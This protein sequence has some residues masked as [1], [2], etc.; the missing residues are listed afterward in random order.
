MDRNRPTRSAFRVGR[1]SRGNWVAQDQEG[2]RG[3]L[4]VSRT[5]AVRFATLANIHDPQDVIMVPG[6]L[7]LDMQDRTPA[8]RAVKD[9]TIDSSIVSL[10]SLHLASRRPTQS[11]LP[12]SEE[13]EE[14]DVRRKVANGR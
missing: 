7:E 9:K 2:L 3:G 10:R 13:R 1:N 6:I 8:A 5:E 12:G 4:F 14:H 11:D